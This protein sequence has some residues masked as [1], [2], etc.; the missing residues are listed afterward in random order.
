VTGALANR[1]TAAVFLAYHSVAEQGAPFL[2]ISPDLFERQLA[3]LRRL[4]FRSGT[5]EDLGRLARGERLPRPTAFLTFDDGYCDNHSTAMPLLVEYGFRPLV[6]LLPRHVDG[7]L[8]F[9]WP[10]VADDLAASPGELRSLTWDQVDEMAGEGAQFGSHTITH[11]HLC[12]LGDEDLARELE[13]SRLRVA[14]RLGRCDT[15]A[16]PFGEWDE[17]V[18]RAAA[19]A[20]YSFAF[21][22]PQG[23]QAATR[24]LCIP[25]VNVDRRDS[26]LRFALKV[27]APGRRLLL[28][29]AGDWLRDARRLGR[30]A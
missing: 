21:S 6:F 27:S 28:S 9:D 25:R 10:E 17:R 4:H 18:E 20:G 7:G 8:P 22:L 16:Y 2:T 3:M 24:P 12:D 19:T 13:E 5:F 26:G 30:A 15:I 14:E 29:S 23:P 11:P 1:S